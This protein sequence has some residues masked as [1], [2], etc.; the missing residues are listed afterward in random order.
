MK[1]IGS[2]LLNVAALPLVCSLLGSPVQAQTSLEASSPAV[3]PE[4]LPQIFPLPVQII[5][6]QG[7]LNQRFLSTLKTDKDSL[8]PGNLIVSSQSLTLDTLIHIA[9]GDVL[10]LKADASTTASLFLFENPPLDTPV[11]DVQTQKEKPFD[12][13]TFV[14][15][16]EPCAVSTLSDELVVSCSTQHG[17]VGFSNILSSAFFLKSPLEPPRKRK[18]KVEAIN[19]GE[20][21][22]IGKTQLTRVSSEQVEPNHYTLIY[23]DSNY[24]HIPFLKER[25]F[26]FYGSDLS[27][28]LPHPWEGAEALAQ[29]NAVCVRALVFPGMANYAGFNGGVGFD[30]R[31]FP[32]DLT[33]SVKVYVPGDL[34]TVVIWTPMAEK[35]KAREYVMPQVDPMMSRRIEIEMKQSKKGLPFRVSLYN[36]AAE[37]LGAVDWCLTK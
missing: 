6:S 21:Y 37:W 22:E 2:P 30:A 14:Q 28:L 19:K 11:I 7:F 29:G 34:S 25:G 12:Y 24:S 36:R 13:A 18:E 5:Q 3:S 15:G 16:L 9:P 31:G 1:K 20:F 26:S 23:G 8:N 32:N 4:S 27:R 35:S 17:F 10:H 33:L